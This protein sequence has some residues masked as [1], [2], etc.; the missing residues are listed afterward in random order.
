MFCCHPHL[1]AMETEAEGQRLA[2][3]PTWRKGCSHTASASHPPL[4][5]QATLKFEG[6]QTVAQISPLHP[7]LC[8]YTRGP[9]L[10]GGLLLVGHTS[11]PGPVQQD[12]SPSLV[13]WL[14]TGFKQP[15]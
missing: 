1:T 12:R 8:L 13:I 5:S 14:L 6:Q 4:R 2:Q 15:R 11:S 9:G 10:G 3:S 7:R